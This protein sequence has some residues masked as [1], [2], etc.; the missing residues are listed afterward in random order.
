MRTKIRKKTVVV[1]FDEDLYK[2]I[3]KL[4]KNRGKSFTDTVRELLNHQCK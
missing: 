3:Q 1:R 4:A 2:S